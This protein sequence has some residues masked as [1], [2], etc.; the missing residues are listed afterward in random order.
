LLNIFSKIEC[1]PL[2]EDYIP[3]CVKEQSK[4]ILDPGKVSLL[5]DQLFKEAELTFKEA[6]RSLMAT[7]NHIPPWLIGLLVI[8]GWNELVMIL[9]SPLYLFITVILL[10]LVYFIRFLQYFP[11]L[12]NAFWD[13]WNTIRSKVL[14]VIVQGLQPPDSQSSGGSISIKKQKSDAGFSE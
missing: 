6:K 3:S 7:T 9:S 12:N 13:T 5:K 4:E 14:D 10:L 1:I 11:P 2:G 8:L